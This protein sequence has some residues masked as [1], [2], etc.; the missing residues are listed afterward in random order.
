M[1]D[2]F[3]DSKY[4]KEDQYKTAKNL[5][6]RIYVHQKFSTN[7]GDWYEWVFDKLQLNEN[8]RFLEIG[9]GSGEFWKHQAHKVLGTTKATLS[10]FSYGMV[11]TTSEKVKGLSQ[12]SLSNLNIMS[13]PFAANTFDRIVGNHMLYH[14]PDIAAGVQEVARVL[15]QD[16]I[17]FS[18]TN[19]EN[20]MRESIDLIGE[21]LPNLDD[22]TRIL[23]RFNLENGASFLERFFNS[24]EMVFREDG[25]KITE[26]EPY[27]N[28][29]LSMWK[30][31]LAPEAVQKIHNRVQ[32]TIEKDG[33]FY[34][35]KATGIFIAKDPK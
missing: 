15:K 14:V 10:D 11:K 2:K 18:A 30:T 20:H 12:F 35:Q 8:L 5:N 6:A 24:V 29:V 13:T 7:P 32:A 27:I 17:F 28:Y 34:I 33:Y 25:L 9:C 19:G 22:N 31:E 23:R 4:L 1:I 3:S 26:T 21:Y 16:G